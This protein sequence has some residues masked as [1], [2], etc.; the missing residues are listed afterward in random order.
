MYPG[1]RH[2]MRARARCHLYRSPVL[3]TPPVRRL[4]IDHRSGRNTC[5]STSF[6]VII[7]SIATELIGVTHA[8][9]HRG[10]ARSR[11]ATGLPAAPDERAPESRLSGP[12]A[13]NTWC[14]AACRICS[15]HSIAGSAIVSSHLSALCTPTHVGRTYRRSPGLLGSTHASN[16]CAV[17]C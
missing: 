7:V 6:H 5:T 13:S 14:A 4:L 10:R 9:A 17:E 15:L 3:H 12:R 11:P 1:D 2:P 8:A 16:A